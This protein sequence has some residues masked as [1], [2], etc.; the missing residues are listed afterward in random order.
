VNVSVRSDLPHAPGENRVLLDCSEDELILLGGL[1]WYFLAGTS[2]VRDGITEGITKAWRE[3][4]GKE[5]GSTADRFPHHGSS[6]E[7]KSF[8][9]HVKK[10]LKTG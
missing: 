8:I 10:R 9:A 4:F 6:L 2:A 3:T 7:S 5:I 1:Y